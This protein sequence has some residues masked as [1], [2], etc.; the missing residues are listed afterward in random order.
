MQGSVQLAE[1]ALDKRNLQVGSK[2]P[3]S[4]TSSNVIF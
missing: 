4:K 2:S 1:N 3:N